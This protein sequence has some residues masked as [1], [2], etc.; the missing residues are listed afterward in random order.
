VAAATSARSGLIRAT[1]LDRELPWR[2]AVRLYFWFL[3]RSVARRIS[4]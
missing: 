2:W 1:L 4:R 3:A